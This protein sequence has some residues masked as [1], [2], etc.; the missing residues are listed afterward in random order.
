M[1]KCYSVLDIREILTHVLTWMSI[2]DTMLGHKASPQK[3]SVIQF[4]I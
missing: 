4:L 2:E 3:T 1:M